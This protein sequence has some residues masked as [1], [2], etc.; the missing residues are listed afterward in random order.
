MTQAT[1]EGMKTMSLTDATLLVSELTGG[2]RPNQ[3]TLYRMAM[4][5]KLDHIRFGKRVLVTRDAVVRLV[6]SFNKEEE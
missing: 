5:G 2:H 3:A 1:N 6:E 4:S